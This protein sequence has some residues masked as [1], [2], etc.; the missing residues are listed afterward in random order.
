MYQSW[1]PGRRCLW[2]LGWHLHAPH[3]SLH[4]TVMTSAALED[5]RLLGSIPVFLDQWGPIPYMVNKFPQGA[6]GPRPHVDRH[7]FSKIIVKLILLRPLIL[8]YTETWFH[9]HHFF[10]IVNYLLSV[11]DLEGG[12][13]C[14]LTIYRVWRSVFQFSDILEYIFPHLTDPKTSTD[15]S[16]CLNFAV[17][18]RP[19]P[20]I[21]PQEI[22]SLSSC[23][24]SGVIKSPHLHWNR[25]SQSWD[26]QIVG[27]SAYVADPPSHDLSL[28][29]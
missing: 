6:A 11:G 27:K 4:S 5:C 23:I 29:T 10:F 21:F 26:L 15:V 3:R 20:Y 13:R 24:L 19:F 22:E 16:K 1:S 12:I 25:Y 7:W 9:K 18:M 14:S 17:S 28:D 2:M 8:L